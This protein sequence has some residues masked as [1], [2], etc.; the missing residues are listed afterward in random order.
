[1]R[2]PESEKN[3]VKL[4]QLLGEWSLQQPVPPRFQER[5]WQR[6][7]GAESGQATAAETGFAGWLTVLFAR[8]AFAVICVTVLLLAGWTTGF[9]RANRDAARMDTQLAQRY[10]AMVDP[11]S[12]AGH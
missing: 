5:V 8:P 1:M 6:I 11:Y 7:E 2:Q 3:D 12:R 9:V 10:V 4:K